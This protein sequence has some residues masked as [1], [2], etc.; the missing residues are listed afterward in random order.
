MGFDKRMIPTTKDMDM[1]VR[2]CLRSHTTTVSNGSYF[3]T[4]KLARQGWVISDDTATIQLMGASSVVGHLE[5][6]PSYIAELAGILSAIIVLN[7]LYES[8]HIPPPTVSTLYCDNEG[9]VDIINRIL[10]DPQMTEFSDAM[11][12]R[13]LLYEL[14]HEIKKQKCTFHVKWIPSHQDTKKKLCH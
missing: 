2:D 5:T 10:Y 3:E 1:L 11:A 4:W 13:D 12:D 7:I 8:H 6:L 14:Q 9:A